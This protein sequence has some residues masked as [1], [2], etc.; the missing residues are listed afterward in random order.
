MRSTRLESSR[1]FL[2]SAECT[3]ASLVAHAG[4]IW[5][6]VGVT[7]GATQVPS[8]ELE[9]RV[10]FLLPPDRV[11]I[12]VQ[13]TETVRWGKAGAD[14]DD[15]RHLTKAGAGLKIR[16]QTYGARSWGDRSGARGEVPFGPTPDLVPDT[17]FSVLEVDES[18]ERYEGS[19]APAYPRDLLA[20]GAEGVVRAL[21]VVDTTGAVDT[22][23]MEVMYSDDP[24]FTT[25]VRVALVGM[26]FRPAQRRGRPVRQQVLQQFRFKIVPGPGS[27]RRAM[28]P[29]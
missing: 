25:S 22:T 10:F 12:R 9:A 4:V 19:A 28:A 6:A 11:D 18:V 14:L 1:S 20:I 5:V 13:Q 26:R 17:V 7:A 23:T 24:R 16:E 21:Y 2:R 27:D 8:D 15:G 3:A 29:G